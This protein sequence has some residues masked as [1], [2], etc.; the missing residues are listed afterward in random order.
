MLERKWLI[1]SS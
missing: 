1:K